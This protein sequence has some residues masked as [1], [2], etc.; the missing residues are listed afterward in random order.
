MRITDFYKEGCHP[1][2]VQKKILTQFKER[3]PEVEINYIDAEKNRD[4]AEAFGVSGLPTLVVYDNND[5]LVHCS[6][7]KLMTL[8]QLEEMVK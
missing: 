3:H 5:S 6:G 4:V 7:G 8:V 2:S 1:C